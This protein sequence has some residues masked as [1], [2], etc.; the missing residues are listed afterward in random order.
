MPL[1]RLTPSLKRDHAIEAT[2]V[3]IGKSKLVYVLITDKRLI[4]GTEKKRKKCR[5]A[6]IGTTKKG[7]RRIAQSVAAGAEGI[8]GRSGV[9]KFHA[10]VFTCLPRR[11]VKTWHKL[12]RALLL[13]FRQMYGEVPVCNSQGSKM[14]QRG[15]F[16]LFR[17]KR[18]IDIIEELA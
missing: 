10:R 4:Y 17:E 16:T 3:S 8:L 9:R 13:T 5:I 11:I 1:R 15:E 14:K 7:T 12:E 6:Y 18:I 2:R